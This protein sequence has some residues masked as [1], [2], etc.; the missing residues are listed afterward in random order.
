MENF[1][2]ALQG[3]VE[4][5]NKIHHEPVQ[6]DPRGKKYIRITHGETQTSVVCFIDKATGDVLFPAGWHAP[7]KHSPVR[8][9]IWEVGKEGIEKWGAKYLR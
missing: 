9:N 5:V 6:I 7:T 1:D 2:T 3:W 4:R 8:G